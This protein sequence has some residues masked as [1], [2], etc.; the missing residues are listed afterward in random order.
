MR[1][2]LIAA[3]TSLAA[4]AAAA[5]TPPPAACSGPEHRQLDFWVGDWD[6]TFDAGEGRIGQ[7][8]N[9]IT[10][11]AF[12]DCVITEHFEMA[13]TGYIGGSSSIWDPQTEQWR[14]TWVDNQG[15]P[16]VLV[17]GPVEGQ[18]HIF[19]FRT[20]EPRGRTDPTIRRMIWQDVTPDSLTWRWQTQQADGGWADAWVLHY[21]RR[22]VA[23]D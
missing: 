22:D 4:T 20:T 9:R 10:A 16:F 6:L 19:E 15:T 23:A 18:P 5:Q 7:A 21:Q 13:A 14:Q 11:D 8:T 17:G 3:V 2:L 1:A 12:G